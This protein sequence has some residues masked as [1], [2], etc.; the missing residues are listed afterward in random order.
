MTATALKRLTKAQFNTMKA[1]PAPCPAKRDDGTT[2]TID[3]KGYGLY[4]HLTELVSAINKTSLA[5]MPTS[6]MVALRVALLEAHADLTAEKFEDFASRL[7]SNELYVAVFREY[8]AAPPRP[9]RPAAPAPAPSPTPVPTPPRRTAP[10]PALPRSA[11]TP[12]PL[13]LEPLELNPL[14]DPDDDSD[15]APIAPVASRPVHRPAARFAPP[16]VP[17][18]GEPTI[19]DV[20]RFF[21]G[22]VPTVENHADIL[23]EHE[24]ELF[25]PDGT[26]RLDLLED[27][28]FGGANPAR[29]WTRRSSSAHVSDGGSWAKIIGFAVVAFLGAFLVLLAVVGIV[30]A[31]VNYGPI[32]AIATWL[33]PITLLAIM[34]AIVASLV[35]YRSTT[36]S[37][38]TREERI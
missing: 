9:A 12:H 11:G 34:A 3:V 30:G 17:E 16:A 20:L 27:A 1:T 21:G 29:P 36:A 7:P 23:D 22:L 6:S 13:E 26:S 38:V 32:A 18:E 2:V 37:A 31:A 33:W 28:V 25:N 14:D 24:A 5:A 15:D 10:A 19:A 4:E 35:T 8:A